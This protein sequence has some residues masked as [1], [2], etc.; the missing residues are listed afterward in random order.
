VTEQAPTPF[1]PLLLAAG[2]LCVVLGTAGTMLPLLPTTPFLLLA[3]ACFAR[4]SPR[5][6]RWLR[7]HRALGPFL[8]AWERQRALPPGAKLPALLVVLLTFGVSIGW[9]TQNPWVRGALGVL[10]LALLVFLARLPVATAASL[11]PELDAPVK[12]P[13]KG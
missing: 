9:A 3:A 10:A 8:V 7:E 6:H 11:R 12:S 2:W 1:R 13:G 4:S 5:V